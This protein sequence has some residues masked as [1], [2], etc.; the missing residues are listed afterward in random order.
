MAT[1]FDIQA[2]NNEHNKI[3]FRICL[4]NFGI[5][6]IQKYIVNNLGNS[7]EYL[8]HVSLGH[9]QKSPISDHYL[10]P[11]GSIRFV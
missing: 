3:L 7:N 6:R 4:D 10:I 1:S 9:L 2:R 8:Q 5:I 11:P